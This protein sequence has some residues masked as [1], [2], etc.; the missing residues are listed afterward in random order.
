MKSLLAFTIFLS[1]IVYSQNTITVNTSDVLRTLSG[2]ENGMNLNYLMDGSLLSPQISTVQSIK[3]LNVKLLRYPGGE[4]SDN[5]LFSAPPYTSASPRMALTNRK[6]W[7]TG[8]YKF[9]DTNSTEK[10][11]WPSALDFDEFMLMCN[12]AGAVPLIVVAYDAAY[13][14]TP[15]TGKPTKAQLKT[16]AVEWV[17]YANITKDYKVKYWMV[18]NE[19][20]NDPK[21]NGKVSPE[22]YASDLKEFASEMKAVDPSIRIIANGKS[23]WWQTLLQSDAVSLI[24]YLGFSEYSAHDFNGGY[25]HYRNNEIDLTPEVHAA[26]KSIDSYA[27]V[28]ERARL[29]VIAS[30]YNSIDWTGQ[31]D[32]TNNLGHAL[33]NFQT[34]GDMVVNPFVE[35][36]C[37]WNSRWISN[38]S[39]D[40]SLYD[41]F[42]SDGNTN[43]T[44]KAVG[45]WGSG[46]LSTMVSATSSN[47]FLKTYASY[48]AAEK[49]L[50]IFILNKDTQSKKVNVKLE[51]YIPEFTGSKWEFSGASVSDKFPTLERIDS[52][53][54]LSDI[55]TLT[56]APTSVTVI[57]LKDKTAS[58]ALPR[59]E[60]I[61]AQPNPLQSYL[62]VKIN[63]DTDR[64]VQIRFVDVYGRF[65]RTDVRMLKKGANAVTFPDLQILSRGAYFLKIG[66]GGASDTYIVV[67]Q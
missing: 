23:D 67:K 48:D 55:D 59:L 61:S 11:N 21:Y 45:I 57:T 1:S 22:Q 30:E 62:T 53:Y 20:W 10:V 17:R 49:K 37:M 33:V 19:S 58:A 64:K 15:V 9:V 56:V 14:S 47:T 50:N 41:A 27:P 46:L 2:I 5:Y 51:N 3:N 26:I 28:A 63:S 31:W 36:A 29:K 52:V 12:D 54:S 18:G 7:P 4:K 44:G 66:D 65:V 25:E 8:D 6:F 13:N 38:A 35:T 39:T 42:D 24:D 40:Q 16:N 60:I 34:F 32:S 43:A